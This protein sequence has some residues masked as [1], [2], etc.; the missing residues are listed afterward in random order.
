ME[1]RAKIPFRIIIQML[2]KKL[3]CF[4]I[5]M[6]FCRIILIHISAKLNSL[7]ISLKLPPV[8]VRREIVMLWWVKSRIMDGFGTESSTVDLEAY[9]AG[10]WGS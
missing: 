3:S 4:L 10:V 9:V 6:K 7:A 2:Q 5:A 8:F 1:T